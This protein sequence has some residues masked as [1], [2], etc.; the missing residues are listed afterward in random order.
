VHELAEAANQFADAA[1]A[2]LH[3]HGDEFQSQLERCK[4]ARDRCAALHQQLD[5]HRADHGC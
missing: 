2:L 4:K 5:D 1:K 3:L